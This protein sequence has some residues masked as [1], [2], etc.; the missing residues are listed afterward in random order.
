[1]II[2]NIFNKHNCAGYFYHNFVLCRKTINLK[3]MRTLSFNGTA[4]GFWI[5]ANVS[6]QMSWL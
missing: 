2:N 5:L 6:Q 1:M 3:F 4:N